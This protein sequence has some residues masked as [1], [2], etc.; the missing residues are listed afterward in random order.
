MITIPYSTVDNAIAYYKDDI[1]M[2]II[3]LSES[4]NHLLRY[5]KLKPDQKKYAQYLADNHK[6]IVLARPAEFNKYAKM[7]ARYI[8]PNVMG[9]DSYKN[10]RNK[11]LDALGYENKRTNFYPKYFTK[12]GI[13]ACA[14]C[15]SQSTVTIEAVTE[16]GR[17]RKAK[18]QVDHYF[19]KSEYPCFS[20]SLYNL[21]PVCASC[22]NSKGKRKV[23]FVLYGNPATMGVSSVFKFKLDLT[24]VAKYIL[25][26]KD[27][28][29][30]YTF[31]APAPKKGTVSYDKVFDIQGI[32]DT[33]RDIAEELVLKASIYT[34]SYKKILKNKFPEIFTSPEIIDR[35][36]IGNYTSESDIHKRPMAKFTS[37]IA[38]QVGLI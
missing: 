28:T 37:D 22:N 2:H 31:E 24:S 3:A 30:R 5:G 1:Q 16:K 20:I 35:L 12:I 13:K 27:D 10:F 32:Y 23:D 21:Y 38:K 19:P 4:L 36:L 17:K 11:L 8:K 33:Q 9:S 29:I 7:F 6:K 34:K 15:N 14:Y 26:R 18:F 25:E